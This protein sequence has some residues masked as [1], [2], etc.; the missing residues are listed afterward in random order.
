MLTCRLCGKKFTTVNNRIRHQRGCSNSIT[1]SCTSCSYSTNRTDNLRRHNLT[2]RKRLQTTPSPIQQ[3]YDP[4]CTSRTTTAPNIE[5]QAPSTDT[6]QSTQSNKQDKTFKHKCSH[7]H[8]QYDMYYRYQNH[9]RTHSMQTTEINNDSG[10]IRLVESALDGMARVYDITPSAGDID[11]DRF[12][13][14]MRIPLESVISDLSDKF[15]IKARFVAQIRY[16]RA[17]GSDDFFLAHFTSFASEYVFDF[18]TWFTSHLQ[19]LMSHLETFNKKGSNWLFDQV[20]NVEV[21]M[22]LVPI[23]GGGG[24]RFVLP[25]KLQ[26]SH[27]IVNVQNTDN[28]CFLYA[29]LTILHYEEV[30]RQK[31]RP[32]AYEGWLNDFNLLDINFPM[33]IKDIAKFERQNDIKINLHVYDKGLQGLRYNNSRFVGSKTV[34]LLLVIVDG[35]GHYCAIPKLSRLYYSTFS[36]NHMFLCERCTQKFSSKDRLNRHYEFCSNGKPQIEILPKSSNLKISIDKYELSPPAVMF[37][38]IECL[39]KDGEHIP[40]AIACYIVWN[41]DTKLKPEYHKWIG[42]SCIMDFLHFLDAF[43]YDMHNKFL[44]QSRQTIKM[45]D[46]DEK[47]FE[48]SKA[49]AR[50]NIAFND[51]S[52]KVRDHNHYNGIYRQCLCKK[53]NLMLKLTRYTLPIIFHN[54]KNYDCHMIC[55][56]AIGKMK[57]WEFNVIAATSDKYFTLEAKVKVGEVNQNGKGIFY[58]LKFMDSYQFL[59]APLSRLAESLETFH[60]VTSLRQ[61]FSLISDETLR[62]KGVFPYTYFDSFE[63]LTET[64]LPSIDAFYNDL[65]KEC[66]TEKEYAHAEK[67]WNEFNCQT[68]SDYLCAYLKLDVLL[69]CDIFETFR[70]MTLKEDQIDPVH[71]VSLP[72]MSFTTALQKNKRDLPH[73]LTDHAMYNFFERGIRGGMTFTNI[74]KVRARIP[75]LNNHQNGCRHLTYIDVNNL[76]GSSLSKYLPHS[77]FKWLSDDEVEYFNDEQTIKMLCDEAPIGYTFEVDLHIPAEIHDKTADLPLAPETNYVEQEM[78]SPYMNQFYEKLRPNCRFNSTKKLLLHHFDKENYIVHFAVLKYYLEL[79][80]QLKKVHSGIKYTQ[81]PWLKSYIEENSYKRQNSKTD[82][83]KAYYKLRNNA[84]YG[85]SMENVRK[86]RTIKLLNDQKKFHKQVAHP[87]YVQHKIFDETLVAVEMYKSKVTLNKLIYVGQSVLDYSKLEMYQLYYDTIKK[88][89]LIDK[90]RL[91]GGDTDSFFLCLYTSPSTSLDD[92]FLNMKDKFDSSNYDTDHPLYSTENKAKLGRFKNESAGKIIE[93]FMI[94]KPKAYSMLY[95]KMKES[96]IESKNKTL[97]KEG[98][99]RFKGVP[100][101]V[102]QN[103]T[104]DHYRQAYHHDFESVEHFKLIQ[105]KDHHVSTVNHHKRGRSFWEDKRCWVSKNFSLPYGHYMLDLPPPRKRL[106]TLPIS[107][108]I[109]D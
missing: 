97:E 37:A 30:K 86:R 47:Q 54:F 7:C 108:D 43:S 83:E 9:C 4:P 109:E 42:E 67:A 87:L 63:K 41:V 84:I 66:C 70:A 15:Q 49:C 95:Y 3:P 51:K 88:C 100:R 65:T 58:K 106:R 73:L 94:A 24:P 20:M 107:G 33:T 23:A 56:K 101:A 16:V 57:N 72:H 90:T 89:P 71:F 31:F 55:N 6:K 38:D 10:T 35:V 96:K 12:L 85:K 14:D 62:Q 61:E 76:Y 74:H 26:D 98:I 45:T 104:H 105:S 93:E 50:C 81:K 27:A 75:E 18:D 22:A 21:N 69:L 32:S 68:F 2:C 29:V 8:K 40:A 91:C 13:T 48:M 102:V 78:F 103:F 34:N 19:K 44:A 60:H 17:D 59:S 53:C 11:L 25:K 82:F 64:Q 28:K 46:E 77:N 1:Y 92:I 39:I 99:M 36:S 5:P 80:A 79:G 52:Q